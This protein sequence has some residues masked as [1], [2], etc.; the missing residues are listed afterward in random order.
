MKEIFGWDYNTRCRCHCC[1]EYGHIGMNCVKH[2]MRKKYNT[3]RCFTCTKLG[4]LA[5]N[6][7]NKGRIEDEKKTK[8]RQPTTPYIFFLASLQVNVF[9]FVFS[10]ICGFLCYF[11]GLCA[12]TYFF[13][14]LCALAWT[15][16]GFFL[17]F[18][19]ANLSCVFGHN[20][21]LHM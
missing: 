17:S 8:F 15:L 21:I 11:V 7:M 1:G 5:K 18:F 4:H 19:Y 3:I 20:F 10:F 9:M 16:C 14:S 6:F 12:F 13:P 2:H